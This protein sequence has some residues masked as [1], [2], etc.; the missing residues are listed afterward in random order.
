MSE[1]V[2]DKSNIHVL[3]SAPSA[4]QPRWERPAITA[5][6]VSKP[7]LSPK[8]MAYVQEVLESG[9]WGYGPVSKD[10][11]SEVEKLYAEGKA[12]LEGADS[13]G[14]PEITK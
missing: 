13:P 4:D 2:L 14:R 8:A 6:L 12:W 3:H 7:Y 10:L 11:Q 9:W 5:T 1:V